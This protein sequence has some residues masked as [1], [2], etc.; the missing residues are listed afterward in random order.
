MSEP[1][2]APT[3]N[4]SPAPI[5]ADGGNPPNSDPTPPI[6]SGDPAPS[7]TPDPSP[8]PTPAP[9]PS[10]PD[11]WRDRLAGGDADLR[12]RL[13]RFADP[14]MIV[15]SWQEADKKITSGQFKKALPDGAKPEEVAAY[16][17][18]MGIPDEPEKY[19]LEA[20]KEIT[21]T[22]ADK[23]VLEAVKKFAHERALDPKTVQELTNF[24]LGNRELELQT[25]R[26]G[27]D[28]VVA[29]R[30][31]ELRTEW[32]GDYNKNV[33][34][35]NNFIAE[36]MGERGK[37]LA[38][39]ALADGTPLGSHPMFVKFVAQAA[40]SYAPPEMLTEVATGGVNVESRINDLKKLM[41]DSQSDYWK[42]PKSQELQ[43]EYRR[44]ITV[45]DRQKTRAA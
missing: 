6:L 28:T 15:K 23:P 45:R 8:A 29:Q 27:A 14:T 44:L 25:F 10:W 5:P 42:G 9:T 40:R 30:T 11:D 17:K 1:T 18:E 38:S 22:D 43:S 35:G 33:A 36:V 19:P 31:G 20:P 39:V 41:G 34:L 37:E 13:D 21:L 32:G 16:R 3:P 24:Y 12:K 4:P 26:E 7:P 2:P